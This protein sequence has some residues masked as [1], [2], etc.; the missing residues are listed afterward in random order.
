MAPPSNSSWS[1]P[2]VME[3]FE[4]SIFLCDYAQAVN[5]KL[6]IVGG[7]W[8][9]WRGHT[10]ISCV[11]ALQLSSAFSEAHKRHTMR[12]FLRDAN[13]SEVRN[14]LVN[15]EVIFSQGEF[16]FGRPARFPD[17]HVLSS[18]VAL[19]FSNLGLRAGTYRW[20]LQV[21]DVEVKTAPMLVLDDTLEHSRPAE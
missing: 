17:D 5:G 3:P 16:E 18:V 20:V 9:N 21:D 6:Y 15:D 7:A 14:P 4:A 1:S 2:S 12:V 10:P 19:P 8:D 13:G 11:I